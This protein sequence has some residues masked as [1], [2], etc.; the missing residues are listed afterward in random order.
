M[1]FSTNN[2]SCEHCVIIKQYTLVFVE[3]KDRAKERIG[4]THTLLRRNSQEKS[5]R[6]A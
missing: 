2:F 5:L 3:N 4:L 1:N 6:R